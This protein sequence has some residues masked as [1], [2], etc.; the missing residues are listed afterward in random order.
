MKVFITGSRGYIGSNLKTFLRNKN[1]K[2]KNKISFDK[3][4][5]DCIIHCAN[6][7]FDK[8]KGSINKTNYIFS[9]KIYNFL[10]KKDKNILFLNLSTFYVNKKKSIKNYRY[11]ESKKKFS[12]YVKNKK[13]SHVIFIN[14]IL[15]TIYGRL[16]NKKDFYFELISKLKKNKPIMLINPF[17]TRSFLK[18]DLLEKKIY[19]I[20]KKI[21]KKKYS[22][23]N[24]KEEKKY[25]LIDFAKKIKKEIRSTSKILISN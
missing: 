9:K 19:E 8:P 7:F 16:G 15:P 20:L 21:H 2:I 24:I 4:N 22:E 17:E 11:V 6:K 18:I 12:E 13:N 5:V 1:Y 3:R 25:R 23:I 10:N 14:L